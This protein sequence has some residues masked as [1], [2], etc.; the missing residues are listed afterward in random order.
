MF[1]RNEFG[2]V[3]NL[4]KVQAIKLQEKKSIQLATAHSQLLFTY[5]T[6]ED[7]ERALEK[8]NQYITPMYT[9]RHW[10]TLKNYMFRADKVESI[11]KNEMGLKICLENMQ[12]EVKA[13]DKDELESFLLQIST[14][15][16]FCD[17][18]KI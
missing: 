15:F 1:L 17:V 7:Y 4:D 12:F 5:K 18:Q 2:E 11:T 8:L 16:A 14:L 9:I 10:V 13:K 6:E 3:I